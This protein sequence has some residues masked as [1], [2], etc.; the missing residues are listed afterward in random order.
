MTPSM[1]KT[2]V[3]AFTGVQPEVCRAE[4]VPPASR[5]AQAV[6][7]VSAN[8][9]RVPTVLAGASVSKVPS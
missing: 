3:R 7:A 4:Y 9:I 8:A 2:S 5:A 6:A 1:P